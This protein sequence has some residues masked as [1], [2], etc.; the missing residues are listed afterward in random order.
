MFHAEQYFPNSS[1]LGANETEQ[2]LAT[3]LTIISHPNHQTLY[4][5]PS[6]HHAA[7]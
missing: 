4:L 6:P 7:P 1:Q 3:P 5:A 2:Y